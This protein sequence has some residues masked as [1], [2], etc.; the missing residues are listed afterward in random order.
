MGITL[1]SPQIELLM[2]IVF[3]SA[4][5]WGCLGCDFFDRHIMGQMQRLLFNTIFTL[6]GK[7][8]NWSLTLP[9]HKH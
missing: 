6:L 3:I 5:L 4:S 1:R 8:M 9:K 7:W 2:I